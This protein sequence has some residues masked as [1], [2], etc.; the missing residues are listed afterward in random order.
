MMNKEAIKQVLK[1]DWR[2]ILLTVVITIFSYIPFICLPPLPGPGPF[3]RPAQCYPFIALFLDLLTWLYFSLGFPG[4]IGS[5]MAPIVLPRIVLYI[6][7]A[8]EVIVIYLL[9]CL[10]IFI[11]DK[12]RS[13]K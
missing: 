3:A 8:I 2:K 10:I 5:I 12:F 9:S 4:E 1:P 7:L 11:F 13:R 6:F